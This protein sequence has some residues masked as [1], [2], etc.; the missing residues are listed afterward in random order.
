MNLSLQNLRARRSLSASLFK[1]TYGRLNIDSTVE[2]KIKWG[3][4]RKI[5]NGD[6]TWKFALKLAQKSTFAVVPIV[7]LAH[8]YSPKPPLGVK[9]FLFL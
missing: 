8:R 1:V 5:P 2:K 9:A 4:T 3:G 7:E 6:L